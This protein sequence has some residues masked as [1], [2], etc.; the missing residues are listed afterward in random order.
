MLDWLR[1]GR[2]TVQ[3]TVLVFASGLLALSVTTVVLFR[4]APEQAVPVTPQTTSTHIGTIMRALEGLSPSG[5]RE[6]AATYRSGDLTIIL[7]PP[8]DATKLSAAPESHPFIPLIIRELPSGSKV[9]SIVDQPD[10]RMAVAA[11]LS[12]GMPVLFQLRLDPRPPAPVPLLLPLLFLVAISIAL[13]IWAALRI[14]APLSRFSAAVDKFGVANQTQPLLEEGPAEIRQATRAFNRMSERILRLIEDRTQMMMAISHDLR[15]PL[16]RLRLRTEDV[17]NEETRRSML[18]DIQRMESSI[19]EAVSNLRHVSATEARARADLPSLLETICNEFADAGSAVSYEGPQSLTA[20]VRPLAMTR[21]VTNLVQ[22]ATKFG[23]RVTVRLGEADGKAAVI[24]IEDDGP[25]IPDSEKEA[26]L[27]PFYRSD[28]ARQEAGGFGLGL[29]IAL[30]VARDHGGTLTLHDSNPH[31]LRVTLRLP[32]QS[33]TG[34]RH[35]GNRQ[36]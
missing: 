8:A 24:D 20:T 10:H 16:T 35:R 9:N 25:G 5:R 3:I 11:T 32:L 7:A 17:T 27:K 2:I 30:E 18:R 12:D 23:S 29:A 22:N 31:G 34:N 15:T 4:M 36:V 19:S 28:P 21:A 33:A 1:S 26:V 14:V 13:F 6:L